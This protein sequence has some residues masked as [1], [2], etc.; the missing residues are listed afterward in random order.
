MHQVAVV[1]LHTEGHRQHGGTEAGEQAQGFA[2]F[3]CE[4]SQQLAEHEVFAHAA[5]HLGFRVFQSVEAFERAEHGLSALGVQ[6]VEQLQR[7]VVA[8]EGA[9]CRRRARSSKLSGRA[10]S[11]PLVFGRAGRGAEFF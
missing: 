8:A 10:L 6:F 11:G 2:F 5:Q 3:G 4:Q 7:A 9:W 1:A